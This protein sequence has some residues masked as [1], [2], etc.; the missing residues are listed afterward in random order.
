MKISEIYI[1]MTASGTFGSRDMSPL[2]SGLNRWAATGFKKPF[3]AAAIWWYKRGGGVVGLAGLGTICS[4]TRPGN[5]VK[6]FTTNVR[7]IKIDA[8]HELGHNW[9]SPHYNGNTLLMNP[10]ITGVNDQW[11]SR[12]IDKVTTH[13][14]S[15]ACLSPCGIVPILPWMAASEAPRPAVAAT[16]VGGRYL[17][18]GASAAGGPMEFLFRNAKGA[19]LQRINRNVLPGV[20]AEELDISTLPK[21]PYFLEVREGNTWLLKTKLGN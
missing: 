20:Y 11:D 18:R 8:A 14:A 1:E 6:D 19:E 5:C 2:L 15:R 4:K 17:V 9:S 12:Q 21:T 13:K 10:S 7:M 3:D 16:R